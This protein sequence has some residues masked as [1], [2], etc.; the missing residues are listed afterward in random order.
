MFFCLGEP[1]TP[2]AMRRAHSASYPRTHSQPTMGMSIQRASITM[3]LGQPLSLVSRAQAWEKYLVSC[4]T[5]QLLSTLQRVRYARTSGT[6]RYHLPH[7]T[8]R[9]PTALVNDSIGIHRTY[10]EFTRSRL[11]ARGTSHHGLPQ[12]K[13]KATQPRDADVRRYVR[14]FW[15][16]GRDS[17][18]RTRIG[19]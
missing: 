19:G 1:S 17:N 4:M 14:A 13:P 2:Q 10:S 18:P 5:S 3:T 16:R 6:Q 7:R 15:R 8:L 9:Q 11:I 12:D